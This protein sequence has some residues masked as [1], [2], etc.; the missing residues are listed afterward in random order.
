M[1]RLGVKAG[2]RVAVLGIDDP[3]FLDQLGERTKDVSIRR[4]SRLD[5]LFLGVQERG[6]LKRL[7][8]DRAFIDPGGAIWVVWPKGQ[9]ELTENHVRDE[10][11]VAGL[12][13]R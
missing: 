5:M 10:A 1:D 13:D 8:T 9:K 7:H 6:K 11:I 3:A 2:A 4:R 12:R